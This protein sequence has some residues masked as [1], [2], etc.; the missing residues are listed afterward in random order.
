[1]TVHFIG[2]GPGA[3]DLL[4]LRGRSLI[5]QC[6]LCLYAGYIVTD[7]IIANCPPNA[8]IINT[9]PLNLGQK[10]KE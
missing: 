9:A 3:P 4:T 8:K 7:E 5:A 2:A 6:D 10:I 1:M